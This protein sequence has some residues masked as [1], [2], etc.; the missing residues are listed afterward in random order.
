MKIKTKKEKKYFDKN[1]HN[2]LLEEEVDKIKEQIT[3]WTC[4]RPRM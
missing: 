2:N 3:N 4:N 1:A